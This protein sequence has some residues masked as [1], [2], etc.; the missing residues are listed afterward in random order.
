[1]LPTIKTSDTDTFERH[2]VTIMDA[3]LDAS[4]DQVARGTA[5]YRTA[6]D[7]A[8]EL[9]DGDVKLGAGVIAAFS[10]QKEWGLNLRLARDAF[11]GDVH[12][13]TVANC[14]KV[15]RILAGESPETVIPQAAKTGNFFRNIADL[16]DSE[17]VTID[18]HASR[19]IDPDDPTADQGIAT[20]G[21]YAYAAHVYREAARRLSELPANV[22]AVVWTVRVD[23]FQWARN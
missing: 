5:W 7:I 22:Q 19:A 18:R 20:A 10:P 3:Y 1:M 2:V 8:L 6:H 12:G 4:D 21:R 16:D 11:A 17:S 23:Q 15:R 9:G 13:Q 14:N